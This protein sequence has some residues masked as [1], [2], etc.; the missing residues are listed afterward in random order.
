MLYEKICPEFLIGQIIVYLIINRLKWVISYIYHFCLSIKSKLL[1]FSDVSVWLKT[2]TKSYV[3]TERLKS[4][5]MENE[6]LQLMTNYV[7]I[8]VLT[9]SLHSAS[10]FGEGV[11]RKVRYDPSTSHRSNCITVLVQLGRLMALKQLFKQLVK[12][13]L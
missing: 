4:Q 6:L 8:S 3:G 2:L 11:N 9:P 1:T 12:S 5:E 13:R 7:L 10:K